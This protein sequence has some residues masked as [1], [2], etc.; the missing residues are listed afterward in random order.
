LAGI[1]FADP[2]DRGVEQNNLAQMVLADVI[3]SSPVMPGGGTMGVISPDSFF[4]LVPFTSS[5]YQGI[6]NVY[7]LGCGVPIASGPP[8]HAPPT[9]YL[10]DLLNKFGPIELSSDPSVN[11]NSVHLLHTLWSTRFRTHSATADKFFTRFGGHS[12][13]FTGTSGTNRGAVIMLVGDAAHIHSPAGGQGM[14]LGLRDATYLGPI[15]AT[16]IKQRLS[17]PSSTAQVSDPDAILLKFSS[18]RRSRALKVIRMTKWLMSAVSTP[19]SKWFW[20]FSVIGE[21]IRNVMIKI[22]GRFQFV[23]RMAAWRLSGMGAP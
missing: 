3:F 9:S 7:R 11:P 21:M 13:E 17:E 18:V 15:I 23:Q 6:D 8:P 2:D 19:Q 1:G 4:V 14:N 12:A 22:L 20:S 10:Q 16:H 5:H